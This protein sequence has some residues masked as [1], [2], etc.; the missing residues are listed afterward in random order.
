MRVK[1]NQIG[2]FLA[3]CEEQSFT[4]A[5]RR[6]GVAQPSLTRAIQE[7]ESACGGRLFDRNRSNVSLTRLGVHLEQD[8]ARIDRALSDV[9]RKAAEF[10]AQHSEKSNSKTKEITCA[11]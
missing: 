3:L 10:S 5:A 9:A 11:S 1:T 2:Y 6:C 4:R 8:F 7:L